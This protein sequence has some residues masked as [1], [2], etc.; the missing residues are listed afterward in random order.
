MAPSRGL[1]QVIGRP[2]NRYICRQCRLQLRSFSS[3]QYAASGHS[4]WS[5]IKHDKAVVDSRKNK[6]R[7]IFSQEIATAS[8]LFGGN[9]N[10]NPRLADL[11]TKAKREGFAKA[12]IEAAIARGQGRSI[13]GANLENVTVEGILPNNVAVIVECETDNKLRTLAEVR[14]AIKEHGG[15]TTP[16]SYLFTKKGV[17][18]FEKKDGVGLEEVLEAALEAGATDV[19]Q[20]EDGRVVV[21][22]EPEELR[23]VGDA[24]SAAL[25]LPIAT[26]KIIFD[27]NEDTMIGV[28]NEEAAAEIVEF[29]DEL[30]E[31]ES[32]VQAVAINVAQ[33][34]LSP[35]AWKD[36]ATRI[37]S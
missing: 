7:S 31:K 16:T 33:G 20:D 26:S 30:Q 27:P 34:N 12:S 1:L 37:S 11:I 18:T 15:T 24:V 35:D 2:S 9:P 5:K 4:R 36:L 10:S 22:S 8:K 3:S 32:S 28:Q 19:E 23:S 17:I 14:L 13:S 25:E 21:S 6:A 29:L